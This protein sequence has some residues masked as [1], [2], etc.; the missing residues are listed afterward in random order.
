MTAP[1]PPSILLLGLGEL[2]TAILAALTAHPAYDPART[3]IAVL[4]RTPRPNPDNSPRQQ[5]QQAHR[6][7]NRRPRH[8]PRRRPRRRV[9]E[10]PHRHPRGRVRGPGRHA[11]AGCAGGGGGAGAAVAARVR[12]FVPWQFGVDY[13]AVVD[14][15]HAALV[16]E[17]GAVRRLLESQDAVPWTVVS[18]G[19]FMSFLVEQA[20]FGV[21]DLKARA[22]RALGDA[23]W[24]GR[25][26][27]TGVE[28]IGRVVGELCFG[29]GEQGVLFI[30]GQTVT[31]GEVADVME[32]V[33]GGEWKREV[34]DGE[35]L[36]KK[37]EERPQD[38]M[39]KYQNMFGGGVGVAWD[40][41]KTWN[42]QKGV[43]LMDLKEYVEANKDRL[44]ALME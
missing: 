10:I 39:V 7:R 11:A 6:G 5:Q 9:C 4:R 12:R 1:A 24:D 34:W 36:R 32:G 38:G 30:A 29:E 43:K 41:E 16:A 42:Y 22:V 15:V 17:M 27:V 19:L 44:V 35:A 21:V 37:A 23:G 33:L 26:T 31:Y 18:A 14:P 13:D 2:G 28:G 25:V 40:M 8:H 3:R 20:G